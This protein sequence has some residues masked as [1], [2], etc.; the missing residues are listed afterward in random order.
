MN[1]VTAPSGRE[2]PAVGTA[3]AL[4][5]QCVCQEDPDNGACECAVPITREQ[6][7]RLRAYAAEHPERAI[8]LSELAGEWMSALLD[9]LPPGADGEERLLAWMNDPYALPPAADLRSSP[10]LGTL[11]DL[12][13]ASPAA[14][15]S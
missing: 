8:I 4:R 13:G 3:A 10:D 5:R 2:D 6:V 11:L 14:A 15:M 7:G 1:E 9:F 12:L